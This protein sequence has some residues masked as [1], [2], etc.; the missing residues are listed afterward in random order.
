M[1]ELITNEQL[2]EREAAWNTNGRSD[3]SNWLRLAQEQEPALLARL[4][5]AE[6]LLDES[7]AY[8]KG[9]FCN[10]G[11]CVHCRTEIYFARVNAAQPQEVLHEN[12]RK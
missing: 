9:A 2:A 11:D 12:K 5:E 6:R 1:S 10:S 4:C 8:T 7:R 3:P